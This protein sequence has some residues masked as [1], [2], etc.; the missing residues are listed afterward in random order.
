MGEGERTDEKL[1][2][3]GG[4]SLG[5][6]ASHSLNGGQTFVGCGWNYRHIHSNDTRTC[7]ASFIGG[8]GSRPIGS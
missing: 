2:D 3:N 1:V 8:T 7:T 4:L 5:G 6:R